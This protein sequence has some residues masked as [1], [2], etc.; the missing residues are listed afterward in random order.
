M[1]KSLS[2][3]L[4]PLTQWLV[5]GPTVFART[6]PSPDSSTALEWVPP[7]DEGHERDRS[8][9]TKLQ[10]MEQNLI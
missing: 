8:E 2:P 10:L 4:V 9:F 3:A 1:Y 7:L 5:D 6:F